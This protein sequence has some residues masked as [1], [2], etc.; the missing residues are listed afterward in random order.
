MKKIILLGYMG[1][2]KT[3]VGK[4]LAEKIN[5]AFIDLDDFIQK[6]EQKSIAEIFKQKG[7]IY[8]RRKES[9]YLNEILNSETGFVLSLG[10]GTPCYGQNMQVIL[11]LTENTF[12]L[13][14]SAKSLVKN[15]QN[16]TQ[17]RPLI[18]DLN[19][20]NVD[21]EEFINKH[22]FERNPFYLQAKNTIICDEKSPEEI[23]KELFFAIK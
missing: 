5:L 18:A 15:L 13:K 9:H 10:G 1:S 14:H 6:K 20:N 21:L 3:L 22:L 4:K 7:E 12:F 17:K 2:G 19:K 16:E 8:F 11:N 23:L